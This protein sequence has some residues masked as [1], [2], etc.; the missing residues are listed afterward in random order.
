M[1]WTRALVVER[2]ADGPVLALVALVGHFV[3]VGGV[4]PAGVKVDASG[5]R[6]LLRTGAGAQDRERQILQSSTATVLLMNPPRVSASMPAQPIPVREVSSEGAPHT[7]P[8]LHERPQLL[9]AREGAL[10]T[11]A[12]VFA[13]TD[14]ASPPFV[15]QRRE[16]AG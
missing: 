1:Q 2:G 6:Q 16:S 3:H 15:G 14:E 13:H 10:L 12:R 7:E 9:G 8:R 5:L 4:L 11:R